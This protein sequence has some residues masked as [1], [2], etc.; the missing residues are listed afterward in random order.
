LDESFSDPV[1]ATYIIPAN[2]TTFYAK[3]SVNTYTIVFDTMDGLPIES[4]DLLFGTPLP[5]LPTPFKTGYTFVAWHAHSNDDQSLMPMPL[6][7]PAMHMTMVAEWSINSYTFT[8]DTNG[9][10]LIEPITQPYLTDISAPSTPSK[11][12]HTFMGWY[13]DEAL[14]SPYSFTTMPAFDLT[15]YARWT[16]NSYTLSFDSNEGS[17]IESMIYDFDAQLASLPTPEREGHTFLGWTLD[18]AGLQPF[19]ETQMPDDDVLLFAQWQINSYTLTFASP[20][21]EAPYLELDVTFGETPLLP[22]PPER[23]GYL[24][25]GWENNGLIVTPETFTMPSR[26]VTWTAVWT[27][28]QSTILFVSHD[29]T[30]LMTLTSGQAIGTLPELPIKAGYVFL[31]W[32]L[33]PHDA[34]QIIDETYVVPNGQTIRLYPVWEKTNDAA[35]LF[36]QFVSLTSQSIQSYTYEIVVFS[37][38]MVLGLALMIAYK[39]RVHHAE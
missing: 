14:T 17:F 18:E 5:L 19:N 9:G 29:Q 22:I 27:P 24:F 25:V 21:L 11:I 34:S 15:L 39:K 10:S 36:S 35:I 1:D 2:N 31:G 20:H 6:T 32:S 37:T 26:D 28:L 23:D 12:G 4:M 38:T 33:A 16:I 30:T 8:F 3:W 7:M 13:L